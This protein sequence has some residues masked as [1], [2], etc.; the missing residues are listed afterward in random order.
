MDGSE[1]DRYQVVALEVAGSNPVIHPNLQSSI[2]GHRL[3]DYFGTTRQRRQGHYV[4]S[5]TF[6]PSAFASADRAATDPGFFLCSM[7]DR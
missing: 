6:T 7:S 5:S 3:C 4:R 2:E 1:P